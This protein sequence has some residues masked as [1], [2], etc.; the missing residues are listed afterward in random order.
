[1][2]IIKLYQSGLINIPY[3]HPELIAGGKRREM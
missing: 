1:M 3:Q 2:S